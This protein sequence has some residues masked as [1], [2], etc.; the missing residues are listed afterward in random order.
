MRYFMTKLLDRFMYV[1]LCI[2]GIFSLSG[3]F[4]LGWF[5]RDGWGPDAVTST[6]LPAFIKFF[7]ILTAWSYILPYAFYFGIVGIL[8][9]IGSFLFARAIIEKT[10]RGA[11]EFSPGEIFRDRGRDSGSP[12]CIEPPT[13]E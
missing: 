1:T 2:F 9:L 11:G 7:K 10:E 8:S 6:G 3:Y 13:T 5:W 12:A 4:A